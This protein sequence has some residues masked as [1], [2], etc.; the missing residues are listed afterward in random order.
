MKNSDLTGHRAMAWIQARYL[1]WTAWGLLI[2]LFSLLQ[3]MPHAFEIFGAQPLFLVPLVVCIALF[4]GPIGGAA[5]GLAAG[6]L[7]DLYATH[8]YGFNGLILMII[9]CVAGLL[10]WLLL[11]NTWLTAWM[12]CAAAALAQVT[13]DWLFCYL[14]AGRDGPGWVLL[15]TYLPNALYTA[16]LS[17]LF[18]FLARGVIR[19][20]RKRV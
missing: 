13:L 5:A 6:L 12:L 4:N 10:I 1:S 20:L 14:I 9:G 11:R 15:H 7:W 18:Y 2:L 16:L 19:T 3:M 8:I 17:P